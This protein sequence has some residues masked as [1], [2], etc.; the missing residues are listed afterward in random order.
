MHQL[1]EYFITEKSAFFLELTVTLISF[2]LDSNIHSKLSQIL[3]IFYEETIK[4]DPKVH[5]LLWFFKCLRV[6]HN[7]KFKCTK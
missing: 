7:L 6:P 5:K 4:R 1:N 3:Y 2:N